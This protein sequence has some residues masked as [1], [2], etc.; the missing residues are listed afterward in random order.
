MPSGKRAGAPPHWNDSSWAEA[1]FFTLLRP[2]SLEAARHHART[3]PP[4][5]DSSGG[6]MGL[7]LKGILL[8][9]P[10]GISNWPGSQ[11]SAATAN[12]PADQWTVAILRLR[13]SSPDGDRSR[14][15]T[16]RWAVNR[17]VVPS[18]LLSTLPRIVARRACFYLL[19][20]P[21]RRGCQYPPPAGVSSTEPCNLVV[22]SGARCGSFLAPAAV[23]R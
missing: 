12:M 11:R 1:R 6:D 2:S 13:A 17:S 19:F 18:H 16:A 8:G 15:R 21:G 9:L 20:T 14:E 4:L 3:G 10:S 7:L 5:P 22:L 23:L